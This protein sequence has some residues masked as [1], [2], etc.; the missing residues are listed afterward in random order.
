MDERSEITKQ[1]AERVGRALERFA[2]LRNRIA[3]AEANAGG[4]AAGT[5][6]RIGLVRRVSER[7]L[8]SSSAL[9]LHPDPL[10]KIASGP[11]APDNPDE[12]AGRSIDER[13]GAARDSNHRGAAVSLEKLNRQFASK[14]LFAAVV[15]RL[16]KLESKIRPAPDKLP[17]ARKDTSSTRRSLDAVAARGRIASRAIPDALDRNLAQSAQIRLAVEGPSRALGR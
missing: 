4:V 17:G 2:Q 9:R 10:M 13:P 16:A 3:R 12:G 7:A 11:R 14:P 1:R 6:A 5:R 8:E 15:A